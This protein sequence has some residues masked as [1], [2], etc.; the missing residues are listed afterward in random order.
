MSEIDWKKAEAEVKY[1]CTCPLFT[2]LLMHNWQI[3]IGEASKQKHSCATNTHTHIYIHTCTYTHAYTH[4]CT[5]THIYTHAHTHIYRCMIK[6]THALV[7]T[8]IIQTYIQASTYKYHPHSNT[9]KRL[10]TYIHTCIH[11]YIH[12]PTHDQI[13]SLYT[14]STCK[15]ANT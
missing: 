13:L 10:H 9:Y 6:R 15:Y 4:T 12:T 3:M 11:T 14:P 7:H 5:Y 2:L 1:I 8:C